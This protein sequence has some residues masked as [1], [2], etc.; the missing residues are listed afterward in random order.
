MYGPEKARLALP[1]MSPVDKK[2]GI[3]EM[4]RDDLKALQLASAQPPTTS[5]RVTSP[6]V[7]SFSWPGQLKHSTVY[8]HLVLKLWGDKVLQSADGALGFGMYPYVHTA[9]QQMNAL[10]IEKILVKQTPDNSVKRT[11][12]TQ[13][14]SREQ[15]DYGDVPSY[16]PGMKRRH[17]DWA[18]ESI[19]Y[20]SKR[21][22][23]DNSA[24]PPP[25][26]S[27]SAS[28]SFSQTTF[29]DEKREDARRELQRVRREKE[30]LTRVEA[31]LLR[32]LGEDGVADRLSTQP[33]EL[34]QDAR[35]RA[36]EEALADAQ[37]RHRETLLTLRGCKTQ[38]ED[39]RREC[40]SP[41]VVPMLLDAFLEVSQK[42]SRLIEMLD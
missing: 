22:S 34:V 27:G 6:G 30:R 7:L 20:P 37:T 25:S 41:F 32:E 40:R 5:V 15:Q 10:G 26:S 23:I 28:H 19:L 39:V 35:L 21:P 11:T 9:R 14:K 16:S 33:T 24:L 12:Q 1:G 31:E 13:L 18:S 4:L 29:Q 2:N 3:M 36:A 8:K 17:D 38:L 42:S